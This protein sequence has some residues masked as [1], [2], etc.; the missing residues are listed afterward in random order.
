MKV[1]Y[2][3]KTEKK[4]MLI[5]ER[6]E[7][8]TRPSNFFASETRLNSKFRPRPRQD[9]ESRCLF[10]QDQDENHLLMKKMIEFWLYYI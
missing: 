5:F 9:R 10:L 3:T 6:D 1:H 8:E 7:T 4:W 2:E